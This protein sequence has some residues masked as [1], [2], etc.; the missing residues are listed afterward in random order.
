M[1]TTNNQ[2]IEAHRDMVKTMYMLHGIHLWEHVGMHLPSGK[3]FNKLASDNGYQGYKDL[4]TK[5]SDIGLRHWTVLML[6]NGYFMRI[7]SGRYVLTEKGIDW[8]VND[9]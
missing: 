2:L 9:T 5:T 1:I 8:V 7:A 3:Y 4:Y 6:E